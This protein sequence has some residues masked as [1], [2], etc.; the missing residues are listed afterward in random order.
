M[1]RFYRTA[2]SIVSQGASW[3]GVALALPGLQ[4][5]VR[6]GLDRDRTIPRLQSVCLRLA[7]A[8][9]PAK[10]VNHE[11]APERFSQRPQPKSRVKPSLPRI[12]LDTRPVNPANA[13][14][15]RL[16]RKTIIYAISST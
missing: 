7:S 9:P 6:D 13:R 8:A 3:P 11:M 1:T 16:P 14:Q 15:N 10:K 2:W 5:C 12:A 4:L